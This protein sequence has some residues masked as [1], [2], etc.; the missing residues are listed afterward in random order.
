MQAQSSIVRPQ[1][2][3]AENL[4]QLAFPS[5]P[6]RMPRLRRNFRHFSER[7]IMT[8]G[9][10]VVSGE[11]RIQL[12]KGFT[13]KTRVMVSYTDHRIFVEVEGSPLEGNARSSDVLNSLR[14]TG[15]ISR[16]SF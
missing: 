15:K 2:H 7:G 3:Q 11:L 12:R 10:G 6:D 4:E 9:G 5:E 8:R 14:R 16:A 1:V 13:N